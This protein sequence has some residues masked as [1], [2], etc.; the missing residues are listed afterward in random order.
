MAASI[1]SIPA[2]SSVVFHDAR[3]MLPQALIMSKV[4]FSRVPVPCRQV[5]DEK[6]PKL[7]TSRKR[8]LAPGRYPEPEPERGMLACHFPGCE[9]KLK[10][11]LEMR[12]HLHCHSVETPRIGR[13]ESI[14][15]D[16]VDCF[17]CKKRYE[18][19]N[20][21]CLQR[22]LKVTSDPIEAAI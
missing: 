9:D 2:P 4:T 19:R 18:T 5:I 13:L 22:C 11:P 14:R 16:S 1:L 21:L 8:M 12:R 6:S 10:C 17:S 20:E 7:F 15:G 3:V